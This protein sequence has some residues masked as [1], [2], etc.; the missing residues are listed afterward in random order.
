VRRLEVLQWLGLFVGASLWAAAHV[1]GFGISEARCS[2][3]G[4][5]WGIHFDLWEVV[6]TAVAGV[7][8]LSAA[9]AA[10]A[11]VAGTSGWSYEEGPPEGRIRFFAIA[12]L[13]ANA[14]FLVMIVLYA[15]GTTVNIPCR[16]A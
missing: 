5:S 14:I 9:L 11:V 3:A 15:V 4:S 10:G 2:A 6:V 12:A 1:V 16:Q 13:A 7:L 8:V